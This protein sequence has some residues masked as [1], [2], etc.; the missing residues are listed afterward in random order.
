MISCDAKRQSRVETLPYYTDPSFTPIWVEPHSR[1]TDKLHKIPSFTLTNQD[2]EKITEHT[3]ANKIYIADFFFTSCPGICPRMTESMKMVQDAFR[4]DAEVML[5]SHSVTPA[6]D[7]VPVLKEYA[8]A[9]GIISGKWHL[10]TGTQ[11]QIYRLG[12]KSYWVEEDLGIEKSEDEFLH[13]ENFILVDK[14]R[15]IRG[16]YNGLN[17]TSIEQLIADV[18][19]LKNEK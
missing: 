2:G 6:S 17:R 5:L 3:F 18:R 7:S 16:I 19:T 12:R 13:T 15:Q 4:D 11:S 9:H 1:Q 10:A 14:K 8:K